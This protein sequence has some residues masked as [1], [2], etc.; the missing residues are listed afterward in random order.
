[1]KRLMIIPAAGQGSRLGKAGPKILVEVAGRPMIEY[2]LDLYRPYVSHFVVVVNPAFAEAV[3]EHC[4]APGPPVELALQAKPTGM[5][6]AILKPI[7][8]V[9]DFAPEKVWITWCDQIAIRPE[10]VSRLASV[11]QDDPEAGVVLPTIIRTHPYIHLV[12][13][14]DGQVEAVLHRREGDEMPPVGEADLGLFG[15]GRVAYLEDLTRFAR[16]SEASL[17]TGEHNFLPFLSWLR[18]RTR[19]RTFPGTEEIES[20]GINTPQDLEQVEE[21]LRRV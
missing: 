19:V 17:G 9:R 4:S 14:G 11:E 5:L 12:R 3:A 10:T 8:R 7:E 1:M 16:E 21:Y 20:V 13:D 2:L 18:G 6:D 15:L